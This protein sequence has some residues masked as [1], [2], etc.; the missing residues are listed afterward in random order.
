LLRRL[1]R[2]VA[3]RIDMPSVG[4]TT[5]EL[6][7]VEWL[8]HEGD[9]VALGESLFSVQT[10]KAQVEV[11]SVAAGTLLK[12]LRDA[13]ETVRAGSPVAYIGAPGEAVPALDAGVGGIGLRTSDAA[14]AAPAVG[15][16][17]VPPSTVRAEPER[18]SPERTPGTV[19]ALPGARRLAS[20]LGIDLTALRGTGREGVITVRDVEQAAHE[21]SVPADYDDRE[22]RRGDVR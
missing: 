22:R 1:T 4:Q 19:S 5:D 7:I 13:G 6:V 12:V 9:T 3:Q 16:R 2:T 20:A 15:E 8:K 10:D 14:A 11:E 17:A 21:A 18:R